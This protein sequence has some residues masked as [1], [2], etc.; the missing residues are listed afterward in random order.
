M[1][2]QITKFSPHQ[3]AKVFGVLMAVISIVF[4]L[5]FFLLA[6]ALAPASVKLPTFMIFVIP[7]L[8]LV[9]GYVSVAITCLIYNG[10]ARVTGGIEFELLKEAA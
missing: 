7:V 5:P 1:K 4:L 3:N 2:Q 10:F 9:V 6:S 8:Y